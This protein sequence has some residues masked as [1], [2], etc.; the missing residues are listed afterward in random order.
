M[1]P[2]ESANPW[3]WP[4]MLLL[5]VLIGAVVYRWRDNL[6][7]ARVSAEPR[8]ITPRGDLAADEQSTIK[9]FRESSGSVVFITTTNVGRSQFSFNPVEVPRGSGSG[10]IWDAKGHVVTNY[11]VVQGAERFLVTLADKLTWKASLVG[12]APENDLA[13]LRIDAPADSLRPIL[14]GDSEN[15]EVGQKV[16]AIGSPFGLDQT[17]TTGVISA[18]G[19]QI[20]SLAGREIDGVIQTD[21]AI[22]P[23]NSGGPLLDSAGRLI[24]VNTAIAS[25][26]GAY[27]GV[28]FAVPV[29][30]VNRIVPDLIQYGKTIRPG[31]GIYPAPDSANEQLK[32][33][34]VLEVKEGGAAQRAGI[35]PTMFDQQDGSIDLGDVIIA[36]D[37]EEVRR[38][39]DLFAALE[40]RKIGDEV[41][42]SLKGGAEVRVKLQEL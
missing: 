36:I 16:F 4:M 25:P 7:G 10:F 19:R 24:G 32:G 3:R 26:S 34:L 15:L 6:P 12:E 20:P 31:L 18:L 35:R 29:S 30:E 1:E 14:V 17:L 37:G 5:V 33:V 2:R 38:R 27:A 42:V 39:K 41:T 21:A 22:N 8:A 13:V 9:L 11:H 28:G 23:G 40:K